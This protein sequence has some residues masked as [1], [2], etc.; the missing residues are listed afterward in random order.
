MFGL[1]PLLDEA[2]PAVADGAVLLLLVLLLM[3]PYSKLRSTEA[4]WPADWLAE[5][6]RSA[7]GKNDEKIVNL[8]FEPYIG[9]CH[10]HVEHSTDR[11]TGDIRTQITIF[12]L[13]YTHADTHTHTHA[14]FVRF[15][16]Y[17]RAIFATLV[18]SVNIFMVIIGA[19]S[20][21][22]RRCCG[23]QEETTAVRR[24]RP[25]RQARRPDR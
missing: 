1:R 25:E 7:I 8:V 5:F 19:V 24:R 16:V 17:F 11:Q 13:A 10:S 21:P 4:F 23:S 6:V 9:V 20:Y 22:I 18:D 15:F 2:W 12:L 14:L 3:R